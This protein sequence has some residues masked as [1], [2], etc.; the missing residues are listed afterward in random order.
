MSVIATLA[1][2]EDFIYRHLQLK[3]NHM[4]WKSSVFLSGVSSFFRYN[5]GA[6]GKPIAQS[7]HDIREAMLKAMGSDASS[8]FPVIQLR[9]TY[10]DDV[11]DLWYLR[12]DV[13]A[14]IASFDG[15][16]LAREKVASISEMFVGLVPKSLTS[17]TNVSSR[18]LTAS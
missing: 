11:H 1:E 10:A 12:G 6:K 18:R 14:A 2:D 15:E 3:N 17:S 13:M 16:V 4:R 5:P 7:M 8:K 9:V